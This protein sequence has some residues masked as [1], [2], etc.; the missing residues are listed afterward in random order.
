MKSFCTLIIFFIL[1][2][3]GVSEAQEF[4]SKNASSKKSFWL[5][6]SLIF[7]SDEDFPKVSPDWITFEE[8]GKNRNA[9]DAKD[10]LQRGEEAE[11]IKIVKSIPFAKITFKSYG[12]EYQLFL[13]NKTRKSFTDS[14]NNIFAKSKKDAG[15]LCGCYPTTRKETIK[16]WGYPIAVSKEGDEEKFFYILE[17][18][19]ACNS[20]DGW[21]VTIKKGKVTSVS[22][23]I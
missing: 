7:F 6:Q 22:G 4:I 16:C 19:G 18:A 10:I 15:E 20:Y 8:I 3:S 13:E 12:I 2:F 17:F 14:F 5:K 23:Y 11:I 1:L 21:T 9:Y